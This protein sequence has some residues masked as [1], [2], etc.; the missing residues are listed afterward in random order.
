[1][2][3]IR[4][5]TIKLA[6]LITTRDALLTYTRLYCKDSSRVSLCT[7]CITPHPFAHAMLRCFP[8]GSRILVGL[9]GFTA[10]EVVL[11]VVRSLQK[12]Y[13][14]LRFRVAD[15]VHAKFILFERPGGN[16]LIVGSHNLTGGQS[17][18]LSVATHAPQA[19]KHLFNELWSEAL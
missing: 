15:S 14:T 9:P 2:A 3:T 8:K 17:T 6:G 18:D 4:L 11:K 13:P 1:M 16:I 7:F 12:E 5:P 10:D 19:V